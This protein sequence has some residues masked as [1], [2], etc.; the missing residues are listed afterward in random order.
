MQKSSLQVSEEIIFHPRSQKAHENMSQEEM[1]ICPNVPSALSQ[2][3]KSIV[4]KVG[5]N[6]E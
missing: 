3:C 2:C 6:Y 5:R 1:E 4:I